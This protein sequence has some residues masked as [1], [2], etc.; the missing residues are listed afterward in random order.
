MSAASSVSLYAS[1]LVIC[2]KF[3]DLRHLESL[4]RLLIRENLPVY[5]KWFESLR[6]HEIRWSISPPI[7]E[8]ILLVKG[9]KP[10]LC[11]FNAL[12]ILIRPQSFSYVNESFDWVPSYL[13]LKLQH[14]PQTLW[15]CTIYLNT[16]LLLV[17]TNST[18]ILWALYL[19]WLNLRYE[20]GNI[21]LQFGEATDIMW[22]F[23]KLT[24][25]YLAPVN[26]CRTLTS[27]ESFGKRMSLFSWKFSTVPVL[28]LCSSQIETD[29]FTQTGNELSPGEGIK[30]SCMISHTDY[31][32][33][34]S[35]VFTYP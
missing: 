17:R 35:G 21:S 28:S 23:L 34:T 11:R 8:L 7:Y 2:K 20:K 22:R 16:S 14:S 1:S 19:V 12:K 4:K 27:I 9:M 15:A 6:P 13:H 31:Y 5:V 25:M 30:W 29:Y 10:L 33:L 26:I 18:L 3:D 32:P 24:C